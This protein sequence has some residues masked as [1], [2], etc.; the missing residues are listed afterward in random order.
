M[1]VYVGGGVARCV[2]VG[3]G[4]HQTRIIGQMGGGWE[5]KREKRDRE[6]ETERG[7]EREGE[8]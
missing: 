2:C 3:G 1:C 4:A 7:R 6:S 5:S 8:R